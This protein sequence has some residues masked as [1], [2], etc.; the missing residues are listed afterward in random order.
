MVTSQAIRVVHLVDNLGIG[1]TELHVLRLSRALRTR[2]IAVRIVLIG[3]SGPLAAEYSGSG[4]EVT[5]SRVPSLRSLGLPAALGRVRREVL[6]GGT[7][8]VHTHDVYSN[9]V[10]ALLKRP[11]V[12]RPL[13]IASV[14][15]GRPSGL[16]WNILGRLSNWR[17]D[18][19]TANGEGTGRIAIETGADPAKVRVIPNFLEA[20]CFEAGRRRGELRCSALARLAPA[21]ADRVGPATSVLGYVGRLDS[22][23][24]VE[25]L[26]D[27]VATLR[28]EGRDVALVLVGDGP[29][30]AELEARVARARLGDVVAFAGVQPRLPLPHVAFDVLLLASKNEGTP[31]A[32]V[33]GMACGLPIVATHV[34]GVPGIITHQR[35]GVLVNSHVQAD[36]TAAIRVV[37]DAADGGASLGAAASLEARGRWHED[38]VLPQ[39]V[40]LYAS[41]NPTRCAS[42]FAG[43]EPQA[44]CDSVVDANSHAVRAASRGA[45][46]RG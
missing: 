12:G 19:I 1:G 40:A 42:L 38:T 43:D 45:A 24:R 31:N 33:E 44:S 29:E 2:G 41:A 28:A 5:A 13:F 7:T 14:R 18:L 22:L 25:W 36:F 37:L 34:G 20:E 16:K 39:L 27:A 8:V 35:T 30:R 15:W 3:E 21:L 26:V 10:A 46:T 9:V 6:R 23:K 4:I 11:G 32:L 17:A